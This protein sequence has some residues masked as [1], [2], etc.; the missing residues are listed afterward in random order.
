MVTT[1]PKAKEL[2]PFAEKI[3]TLAKRETLHARRQALSVL[4]R[5]SVVHKLFETLAPRFA[6]RPGGYCRIIRLGVR[7]GDSAE[8]AVIELL[9]SEFKPEKATG[10]K[11][12]KDKGGSKEAA[13]KK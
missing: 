13:E 2:R 12:K 6:E 1:I 3:I 9:G 11:G 7:K 8:L 10:K 4:R 5:K